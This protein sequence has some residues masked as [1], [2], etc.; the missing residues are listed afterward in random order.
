MPPQS[1]ATMRDSARWPDASV[2][3]STVV[4][5]RLG[6]LASKRTVNPPDAVLIEEERNVCF[7]L[8]TTTVTSDCAWKPAPRTTSGWLHESHTF[9]TPFAEEEGTAT[10]TATPSTI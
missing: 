1:F 9:A 4:P 10:A 7:S 6:R 8:E 3:V 5:Q 2:A